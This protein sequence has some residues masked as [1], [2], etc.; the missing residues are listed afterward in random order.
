MPSRSA[1]KRAPREGAAPLPA[2][3]RPLLLAAGLLQWDGVA[4]KI[5]AHKR[6]RQGRRGVR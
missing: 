3:A 2:F 6:G 4:M 1:S 5:V